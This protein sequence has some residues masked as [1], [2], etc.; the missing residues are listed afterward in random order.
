MKRRTPGLSSW[1]AAALVAPLVVG[2]SCSHDWEGLEPAGGADGGVTGDDCEPLAPLADPTAKVL[3]V[4]PGGA[5]DGSKAAPL[6]SIADAVEKLAG[7][8]GTI[9]MKGGIYPVQEVGDAIG[10]KESPIRIR[11]DDPASLPRLSGQAGVIA[12]RAILRFQSAS[13][14][15]IDG[16]I[17]SEAPAADG[18]PTHGIRIKNSASDVIVRGNTF[19]GIS[20]SAVGA[21]GDRITLEQNQVD[22]A[23]MA[24]QA[25]CL[26]LTPA[27][28]DTVSWAHDL[29]LRRNRIAG[30]RSY[31]VAVSFAEGAVVEDNEITAPDDA[32]AGIVVDNSGGAEVVLRRN[33]IRAGR[34]ILLHAVNYLGAFS[35]SSFTP[36]DDV[37]I[38]NN[39][40]LYY[41]AGISFRIE[42]TLPAAAMSYHGLTV[43]HNT[44]VSLPGAVGSH[45]L[46]FFDAEAPS[47]A[48]AT[49]NLFLEPQ[50]SQIAADDLTAWAF[51]GNL[52]SPQKPSFAG[53]ADVSQDLSSWGAPTTT[54]ALQGHAK[55]AGS[56]VA[57]TLTTDYLCRPRDPQKP[58]RGAIEP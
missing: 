46:D 22:G 16:L 17:F 1:L 30:C 28:T 42:G 45:C 53:V 2:V 35:E 58:T 48:V 27:F 49:N 32:Y 9:R 23:G 29:R 10:T 21:F 4:A 26:G 7:G 13:H 36:V 11:A 37:R 3:Y 50:P 44:F 33:L 6:G 19:S 25:P 40:L 56:G 18:S 52:W 15:I 57:G 14:L 47:A 55:E 54:A 5:G 24:F 20:G 8:G 12:F 34:P 41:K 38:E 31:G 43:R 51:S 39:I